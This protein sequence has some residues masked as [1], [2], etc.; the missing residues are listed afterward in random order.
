MKFC[1][2]CKFYDDGTRK[3]GPLLRYI[4]DGYEGAYLCAHSQAKRDRDLVTGMA[5]E[6]LSC[7]EMRNAGG[8]G[9][10]G[11]YWCPYDNTQ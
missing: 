4:F 9:L 3:Y 2:E 8:C 11:K 6:N 5:K 10:E 7:S 1:F